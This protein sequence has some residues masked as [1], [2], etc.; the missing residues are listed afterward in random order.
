MKVSFYTIYRLHRCATRLANTAAPRRS[1]R[2]RRA[3]AVVGE[4]RS[5]GGVYRTILQEV[6][7]L[8]LCVLASSCRSVPSMAGGEG[9]A[10][11]RNL[12]GEAVMNADELTAFFMRRR[13]EADREMVRRMAVYYIKEGKDEGINSDTAFAQM[14]LETGFLTFGNLVTADMHN[15]CGLGSIGPGQSG[16]RFPSEQMGVRAHIQHLNAYAA[17]DDLVH[18]LIDNRYRYVTPRGKAATVF[19]LAGTWAADK[20]YGVK[21]DRLLQQMESGG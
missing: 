7:L 16:E 13:P 4:C 2:A 3:C 10:I 1:H 17:T 19:D 12:T 20:E 18:P 15:Y 14:C 11:S 6:A 8:L 21:L 5:V 9:K